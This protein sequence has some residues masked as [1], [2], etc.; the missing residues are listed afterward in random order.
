MAN[1]NA[2]SLYIVSLYAIGLAILDS[3]L[4]GQFA[5]LEERTYTGTAGDV[6]DGPVLPWDNTDA[7]SVFSEVE[8][9]GETR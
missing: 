4:R 9:G 5:C 3:V 7:S 8:G 6:S 2:R 1:V